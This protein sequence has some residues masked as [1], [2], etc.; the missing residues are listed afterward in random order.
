MIFLPLLLIPSTLNESTT[1]VALYIGTYTSPKGS[2]GIYRVQLNTETGALSE[3]SL[4][5][6]TQSP[7]YLTIDPSGLFLYSVTESSSGEVSA[8]KVGEGGDLSFLNN[9]PTGGSDPCHLSI[10]PG[11]K[12]LMA[13]NY[14]S[15]NLAI[16]P[17]QS[18]GSLGAPSGAFQ[19]TGSGPNHSR[20]E[21]P[22]MHWIDSD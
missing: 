20:Q 10:G 12:I 21:G 16:F 13:A 22:H 8:F 17:I 18:D 9:Q 5:A 6:T 7:S 14:S 4:A 3:P 19:N 11:S 1:D 2:K 15:G